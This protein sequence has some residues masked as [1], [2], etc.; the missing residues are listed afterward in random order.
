MNDY[1]QLVDRVD[2]EPYPIGRV[3]SHRIKGPLR[4]Q[5]VRSIVNVNKLYNICLSTLLSLDEFS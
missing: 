2:A 3:E 5:P 1:S 4:T